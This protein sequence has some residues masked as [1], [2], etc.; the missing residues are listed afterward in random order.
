MHRRLRLPVLALALLLSG[1]F[2]E[3]VV[4]RLTLRF[5]AG[6]G[7]TVEVETRLSVEELRKSD[8]SSSLG[9]RLRETERALLAGD[10]DWSRRF[11]ALSPERESY[12]WE[13]EDG[14]LARAERQAQIA[15]PSRLERLFADTPVLAIYSAEEGRAELGLYPGGPGGRANRR[16]LRR[17][18]EGLEAWSETLAAYLEAAEELYRSLE[19]SPE[20]A[21]PV[22]TALF[23]DLLDGEEPELS[24]EEEVQVAVLEE[25]MQAVLGVLVVEG[26]EAHTLNE[27]SHLVYDPFPAALTVEVPGEILEVEGFVA[28]EGESVL[29][30]PGLGLWAALA[31]L[32]GWWLAPD[33]ALAYAR[34]IQ[35]SDEEIRAGVAAFAAAP[36]HVEP[37]PDPTEVRAVLDELLRP[38]PSYRVVWR[39]GEGSTP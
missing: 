25:A 23:G 10:D 38:Q 3:P 28:D 36:R 7:V 32:E 30:V 27:L 26:G 17:M 21:R 8:P 1:C 9:R 12:R 33:P 24:D 19:R 2:E 22:F 11:A 15:D 20:R 5:G 34:L 39:R 18:E 35:D 16:E 4:E 37:A 31:A 13:K 14:L 29:K 6:G